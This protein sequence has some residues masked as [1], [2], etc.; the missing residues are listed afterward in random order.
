M[1]QS[2]AGQR[3]NLRFK[4]GQGI[5]G[6]AMRSGQ[7]LRVDDVTRDRHFFADV[8]VRTGFQTRNLIAVPLRSLHG[9]PIGVVEVLNNVGG[10][11][12]RRR[13]GGSPAWRETALAL[14]T[15]QRVGGL[16][17]DRDELL[18]TNARLSREVQ[19]RFATDRILGTSASIREVVRLIEQ[20][21]DSTVTF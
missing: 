6:E 14:E 21:A 15:A 18:A 17:R 10:L 16:R 8:D 19:G 9:E 5:A 11:H 2:P 3:R 20:V 13:R 12:R 1:V 4:A 7:I